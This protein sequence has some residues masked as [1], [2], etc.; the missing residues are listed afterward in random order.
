[1]DK[2]AIINSMKNTQGA[3]KE[4][5]YLMS[6]GFEPRGTVVHPEFGAWVN[7]LAKSTSGDIPSF[8]K[9]GRS[10]TLGGGFFGSKYAALPVADPAKGIQ[11]I[12]MAK[13]VSPKN[14]DK[15]LALMNELNRE[16]GNKIKHASNGSYQQVYKDAVKLMNSKDID[17]FDINKEKKNVQEAYGDNPFGQSCLLARRLV[18][19]GVRFIEVTHGGWDFHYDLYDDF[20]ENAVSLDQGVSALL[21]DLSAK[22]LLDSTLVVF[23]TEFG[24]SAELNSRAGR[25]HHPSAYSSFLAGGGIK[26]GQKYGETDKMGDKVVKNK[27]KVADFNA[28]IAHAMGLPLGHVETSP[29]GRPFKIAGKG[30]P[31]TALF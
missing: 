28:T 30:K 23:N 26:G 12:R 29:E 5:Q 10:S 8:I 25:G 4:A 11:N 21:A 16:F 3:H 13:D 19:K 17:V 20:A 14:F 6:T 22:G 15:R 31:I 1:M 24:R 18:G 2:C 27:V 9:T 7:K